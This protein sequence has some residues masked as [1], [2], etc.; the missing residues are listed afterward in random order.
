MGN[1]AYLFPGQG[2]AAVGMGRDIVEA[3]P[4][5]AEIWAEATDALPEVARLAFEGPLP[6]LV[7]TIHAQPAIFAVDCACLAALTAQGFAP[8]FV[9]G[10]SL[11]EY[12]ALVAAGALDF[13][14]GLRLVRAR[15]EAMQAACDRPGTMLAVIGSPPDQVE[16]L[17]AGWDGEGVLVVANYNA[18]DQTVV[19]GDVA[20]VREAAPRFTAA[21]ARVAELAVGGAFHSPLMAPA[22]AAFLPIL[23][24]ATFQ[25]ARVPTVSNTTAQASTDGEALRAALR[26]QI[27]GSVRWQQSV[28]TMLAAGVDTFVEIGPGRTLIGLVRRTAG[29]LGL[30]PRLLNVEDSASLAKTRLA[31]AAGA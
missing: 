12:A 22:E 17:V 26:S 28:E 29:K 14:T 5:A 15:A 30:Q 19:A 10:H 16:A 8:A 6:E 7:Q 24:A 27:T 18:P 3:V 4:A 9:A 1:V 23:D 2:A 25:P 13:A 11:G 31:L 21:G 20:T